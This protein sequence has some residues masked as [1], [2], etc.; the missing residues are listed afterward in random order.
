MEIDETTKEVL[1]YLKYQILLDDPT[2]DATLANGLQVLI[3][4]AFPQGS[5]DEYLRR[6]RD[7]EKVKQ[8]GFVLFV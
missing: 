1:K 4:Y 7:R 3:S 2:A 5:F 8:C 6:W